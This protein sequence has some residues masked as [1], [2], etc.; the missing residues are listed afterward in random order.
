MKTN[1]VIV[2]KSYSFAL[3]IVKLYLHLQ[4]EKKEYQLSAQIVRSGTSVGANIEEAIGASSKKDFIA[5]LAIAHKE[6]RETRFWLKLLRDSSFI[7]PRLANSMI[8]GCEELIKLLTAILK[9][10]K[11]S[12]EKK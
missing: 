5:K 7:E 10:S 11:T 1:N 2:E 8:D 3:R 12:I 4:K 9:S 6:S